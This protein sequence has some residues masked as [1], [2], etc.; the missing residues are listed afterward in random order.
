MLVHS[1]PPLPPNEGEFEILHAPPHP[2]TLHAS[3]TTV[4]IH[5]CMSSHHHLHCTLLQ[6]VITGRRRQTVL[7]DPAL[8]Q[9]ETQFIHLNGTPDS[10][11][12][13]LWLCPPGTLPP[14]NATLDSVCSYLLQQKL[15][16]SCYSPSTG[17]QYAATPTVIGGVE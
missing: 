11:L 15:V 10:T 16:K 8:I 4:F 17:F 5:M 7:Q 1:T 9:C 12:S 3:Y 14:A 6:G 13:L 2:R